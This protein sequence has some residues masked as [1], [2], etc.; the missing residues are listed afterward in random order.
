MSKKLASGLVMAILDYATALYYW[1]P[2]K[3]VTKLQRLQN[4]AIKM[5]LSRNKYDSST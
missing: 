3:E 2:N 5:I 1:L 4:Y